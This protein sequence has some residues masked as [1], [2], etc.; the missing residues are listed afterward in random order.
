MVESNRAGF[1]RGQRPEPPSLHRDRCALRLLLT[2]ALR[3]DSLRRI[4][5]SHKR[6]SFPPRISAIPLTKRAMGQAGI[7]PA[8]SRSGGARSIP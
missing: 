7:E 3:K 1:L 6:E 8:T 5:F 4:Q 2:Y